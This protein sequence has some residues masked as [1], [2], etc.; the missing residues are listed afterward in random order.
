MTVTEAK[1]KNARLTSAG[2]ALVDGRDGLLC[3]RRSVRCGAL[4]GSV[5]L[6]QGL[7]ANVDER[8]VTRRVSS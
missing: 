2:A 6:G 3:Q 5:E 4:Q 8:P 7:L 1:N